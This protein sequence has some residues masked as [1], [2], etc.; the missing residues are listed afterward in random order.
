MR[1]IWQ[2]SINEKK[3]FCEFLMYECTKRDMLDIR[4]D[5][6]V[7][8]SDLIDDEENH[9]LTQWEDHWVRP[10]EFR[11]L[12]SEVVFDDVELLSTVMLHE[13]VHVKQL[14][15]GDYRDRF[16]RDGTHR[17]FWKEE[18]VFSD[19]M[20]YEEMPWEVEAVSFERRASCFE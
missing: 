1:V 12:L 5:I 2:H 9:A 18:E 17:V 16:D 13:M 14:L 7:Y 10:R 6:A 19:R 15:R 4:S 3:G 11:V 8:V 20:V